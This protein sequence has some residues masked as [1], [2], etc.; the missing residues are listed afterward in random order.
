M[1]QTLVVDNY[2]LDGS[3]CSEFVKFQH[4]SIE[5]IPIIETKEISKCIVIAYSLIVI[6]RTMCV[7]VIARSS[8]LSGLLVHANS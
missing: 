4:W 2:G 3:F 7:Y 6:V 8:V 5:A 1:A